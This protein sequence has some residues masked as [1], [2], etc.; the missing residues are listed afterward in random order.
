MRKAV[1]AL[2]FALSGCATGPTG[3]SLMSAMVEKEK[4]AM[5]GDVAWSTFYADAI[6]SIDQLRPDP[7]LMTLREH[8]ADMLPYAAAFTE[9]R[10]D[11]E[12]FLAIQTWKQDQVR[13]KL[14]AAPRYEPRLINESAS[15]ASN[16]GAI[17]GAILLGAGV[18][19]AVAA[20]PPRAAPV[21]CVTSQ[22]GR[23]I[24]TSCR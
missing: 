17:L 12:D 21:N 20:P 23:Y 1:F 3:E 13:P 5:R 9:G 19:A 15:T 10:I 11:A 6:R 8:Y 22:T 7:F 14:A 24:N 18:A 2:C 4:V 16:A